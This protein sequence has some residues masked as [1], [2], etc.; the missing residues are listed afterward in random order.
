[1]VPSCAFLYGKCSLV[2]KLG[3]ALLVS[4]TA[5]MA[6]PPSLTVNSNFTVKMEASMQVHVD[7]KVQSEAG[8][9]VSPWW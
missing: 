7:A 6:S 2:R 1:M 5:W 8:V 3:F 9:R 4:V